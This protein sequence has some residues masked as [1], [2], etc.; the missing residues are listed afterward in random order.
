MYS[1]EKRCLSGLGH[2]TL[3][4]TPVAYARNRSCETCVLMARLP[5]RYLLIEAG[6]ALPSDGRCA[7]ANISA[8]H[9]IA[10]T[11]IQ[12]SLLTFCI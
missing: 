6:T 10:R 5:Q 3:S 11:D 7:R 4:F 2:V 8:M 12:Q 1:V 9:V